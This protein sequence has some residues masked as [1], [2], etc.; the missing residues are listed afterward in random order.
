MQEERGL[1]SVDLYNLFSFFHYYHIHVHT[2]SLDIS[3]L[4]GMEER[5]P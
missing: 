4:H 3:L 5:P 1:A 2:D